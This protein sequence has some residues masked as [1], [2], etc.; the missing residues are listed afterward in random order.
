[1][2][3]AKSAASAAGGSRNVHP[4]LSINPGKQDKIMNELMLNDKRVLVLNSDPDALALLERRIL[5]T[6]P[7]CKLEKATS[8][9]EAVEMMTSRA[10]DL[11]ILDKED[12]LGSGLLNF[13]LT[14]K[15]PVVTSVSLL[16]KFSVF[17]VIP[18]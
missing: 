9:R 3:R 6:R 18:K 12:V 2:P 7:R 4:G 15:F 17:P 8:H 5:E 16:R 13:A 10:Y 11:V 14:H 1:V